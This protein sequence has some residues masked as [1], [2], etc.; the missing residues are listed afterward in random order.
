MLMSATIKDIAKLAGVSIST[1]S[2]ALNNNP[3]VKKGTKDKIKGIAKSLNFEF[4]AGARSLSSKITGNIALVYDAHINGFEVS[5][6]INQLFL[7]VRYILEQ[8]DMDTILLTGYDVN[9]GASNIKR[10]VHKKKVDGF[11]I[12]HD[13]ITNDDY[14]TIQA[15]GLPI[16]QL[17]M[18]PRNDISV[19]FDSFYSDNFM[20]GQMATNHLIS[21]GCRSIL[22][23][24]PFAEESKEYS[25]RVLGYKKALED[26]D[27]PF[28][29]EL[30]VSVECAYL[31]GYNLFN[32]IPKI[33]KQVDGIFFQA[34]IQAF[35][36]LTAARE[37]GIDIPGDIKVIGYDDVPMCQT[38]I[39]SLSSIH[40]PRKELAEL[41]CKRIIQR[42]N[43]PINLKPECRYLLPSIVLRTSS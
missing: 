30:V 24:L 2:R 13:S 4:N 1:V 29:K 41:A 11:L 6:Y 16:V 40:Q 34:D 43:S 31:S 20:G 3:R 14:K 42:I 25:Q 5:L 26:S 15:A 9:T 17:H 32:S 22:T 12:V 18:V 10:I 39:P 21:L 19:R 33:I 8:M 37:R 35:G 7:E 28:N 36:F 23:V 27:L 38:V